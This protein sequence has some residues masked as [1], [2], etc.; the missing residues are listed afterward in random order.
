MDGDRGRRETLAAI[1]RNP[2]APAEVLIRLL[3][4][5]AMAAWDTI[6]WRA[7]P[8]EVVNAV[9]AHPDPRLRTAFAANPGVTA[10][11]RARLVDDPDPRVRRALADGP[12]WFR[13][14]V[15]P[16]PSAVQQR[17]L[18][19]PEAQVRRSAARCRHTDPAL[20]AALAD[21]QDADLRRAACDQWSLLPEDARGRLLRDADDAVRQAAMMRGCRDE[22]GLTDLLLGA[23]LGHFARQEVIRYGAMSAATAER[24]AASTEEED[25]RELAANLNVPI[26]IVRTLANDDAHSVRLA[27]SARPELTEP[28][29][30]AIDV[31]I[32]PSDRLHPV[33]WVRLCADPDVL[34]QC[35]ESSN[36]LLRRSAAYSPHLPADAVDLLSRDDDYPVRLLLCENQPTVD[37]E[38]V[39]Q[40][41][42]DCRV[43]TKGGLLGHP[44]FPR[45]GNGRRFADDP[46][47]NRRWLVGLDSEA[48]ADA[49][50]RLLTDADERVRAMAAGHPA[51]PVDLILQSCRNPETVARA[52]SNP[53]LPAATMH[54]YLDEAGVP[55]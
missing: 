9:V 28:E 17:L 45:A 19:D 32:T 22:A 15:E 16:L 35:A 3:S 23:E 21:H 46:D 48:P 39:L 40:T 34:R 24:C 41:F 55:R 4:E 14:P 54:E 47:P 43:I 18:A 42:L 1:A 6:A 29:R 36:T 51:L 5:E 26:D 49:V 33:E 53:S 10:E 44:N 50:V 12:D 25:R 2:A 13:I 38:V 7:L 27:V 37:G 30:T 20:V 52:L 11:Q 31:T 8:D